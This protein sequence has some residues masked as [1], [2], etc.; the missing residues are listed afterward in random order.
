VEHAVVT[1]IRARDLAL[2]FKYAGLPRERMVVVDGWSD[3][4]RR[5]ID[6]A[7]VGGEVVVL[8]TYTALLSLRHALADMGYVGRFWED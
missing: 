6:L 3:A 7:P 1:G 2:R 5:A 8:T 4:I